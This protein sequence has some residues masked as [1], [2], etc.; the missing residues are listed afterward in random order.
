M[1]VSTDRPLRVAV[2]GAGP[3]G[4][5]A[6]DALTRQD[7]VPVL[8]D[9]IDALPTP[10]GLVRY[11]VA[12]DHEKMRSVSTT[13]QAV[14]ERPAVRF[15]GNVRYGSDL[16][17]DDLHRHYD[18]AIW[19]VGAA[20]DRRLDIPGEDLEG[21]VSATDFVAWYCGHPDEP[22]AQVALT[23]E[24]VVVVGAGNVA[25][26][27][28]RVLA[29][30]LADL[31]RTDMHDEALDVLDASAV[32]DIH[33]LA[34]RGPVQAKFTTKELRELGELGDVD[35]VVDPADLELTP[36]DEEELS[37]NAALRRNVEVLKG[38]A[39]RTPTGA[40]RRIHLHFFTRPV[41]LLGTDRVEA[42]RLERTTL[43]ESG[44]TV[45]TG[46]FT[47]LPAQL[48]VRSVGYRGTPLAGLPFD[49]RGGVIP[50]EEGR[51]L[52]EKGPS[53]GEYVAGWIKRGPT[54]VIGTNKTDAARTVAALLEDLDKLR[55]CP[56]PDPESVTAL[57][58]ERGVDVVDLACWNRIDAAE[59]AL[60]QSAGRTRVKLTR[61]EA[62][63]AAGRDPG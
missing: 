36:A 61:R 63:L 34:R 49:E 40:R 5:Y 51:V 52:R 33:V 62:L 20:R 59:I 12:P 55:A 4:I 10:F 53:P 21:S 24:T 45:G 13:L 57:L 11:G 6:A 41:E 1:E 32:T 48:V 47:E 38:W 3:S 7:A 54:G 17:H 15:L 25:V 2:I 43:D 42:V 19:S 28:A 16:T 58:K 23:A 60:G 30:P 50:N 27:V 39:Q 46:E 9:V 18:A 29:R 31:R 8:V 56:E 14:L 26:D 37:G 22:L 35:V 44:R